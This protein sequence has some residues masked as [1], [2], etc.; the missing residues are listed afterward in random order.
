MSQNGPLRVGIG[1]PVG[2]GKTTLTEQLARAFA[3]RPAELERARA[4]VDAFK[5]GA[6]RFGDEMIER[7]HV[8]AAERVLARAGG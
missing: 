5:G 3:P 4:L 6:E 1:G 2:A 8:E 7:M